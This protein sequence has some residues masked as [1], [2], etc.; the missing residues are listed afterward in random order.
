[1]MT[2]AQIDGPQAW[3]GPE[4]Q[5]TP[6]RWTCHLS[7]ADASAMRAGVDFANSTRKNLLDIGPDDFPLGDFA[8]TLA[9]LRQELLHGRGFCLIRG[10]PVQEMS[11]RDVATCF[12]GI[13]THLGLAV[14]Q[15]GKGHVLGHVKDLV[16]AE[17]QRRQEEARGRKETVI[18][19]SQAIGRVGGK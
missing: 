6:E 19:E 8:N 16:R 9:R 4:L 12:W 1:M 15:N 10:L 2:A 11:R 14:S 17:V 18:S 13:G 7:A 3:L 5:E